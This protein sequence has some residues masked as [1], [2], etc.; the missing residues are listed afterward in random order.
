MVLYQDN[1]STIYLAEKRTSTST[2]TRHVN[3][4]FY[5]IHDR[6]KS[7]EIVVKQMPTENMVADMMTKPLPRPI[8]EKLR[9]KLLHNNKSLVVE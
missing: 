6:I 9:N 8:F 2:R 3:I 5:F 1:L 4:R 7:G